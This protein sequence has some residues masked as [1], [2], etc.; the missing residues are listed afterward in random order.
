MA[1]ILATLTLC[2]FFLAQ[3]ATRVLAAELFG[4]EPEAAPKRTPRRA[5]AQPDFLRRRNPA[6]ILKRNI[7]DS[8]RGDLTLEA[9]TE[10]GETPAVA[11]D[12]DP[13]ESAPDCS[14]SSLRLVGCVVSPNNPTWSFAA[15][16]GTEGK[17][18]LYREGSTVDGSQVLAVRSSS[19][20]MQSGAG[21]CELSMFAPEAEQP[22]PKITIPSSPASKRRSDRNA[23]LTEDDLESGIEKISDT[24]FNIQ[25]SMVDKVLANQGAIMKTARVIPHEE[26]GRI[27]G[28]KLYGIRRT[29][30]LGKL[31]IRNGD[32]LRTINGF[33]MTSPDTALEAYS[34]LRT[35]DQL[36]L[37][38]KRQNKEMTI[39]YNVQ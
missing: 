16:A 13:G 30:L 32:M 4:A 27:V 9:V 8:S 38:V 31:G 19:V 1:I 5:S 23:G 15:I 11:T 20:V 21:A 28:M 18:M 29:S 25:R 33:D 2:A 24:K 12:W 10:T 22:K 17:T 37:A 35:A 6:V 36:S 26:N 3:G 7:F 14:N 39:E 34:R